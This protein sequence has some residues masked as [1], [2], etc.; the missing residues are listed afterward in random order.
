VV[1]GQVSGQWSAERSVVSWVVSGQLSGQ[2]SGQWSAER[3][4]VSGVSVALVSGVVSASC[5]LCP[6]DKCRSVPLAQ[7]HTSTAHPSICLRSRPRI[8]WD[9]IDIF[10]RAMRC[11][12]G[13]C[14]HAV[15]VRPSVTFVDH[16]KT[17]KDIFEIFSPSGSDTILVF[18]PKG[19]ADIPT[20][21]PLTG[22]SNARW[23][24]K[25][26]IFFT[27]ISLYLRNGNS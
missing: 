19:G 15:S 25:M 3:S 23:Y 4:V 5:H 17:N 24:D 26:T 1:S 12:R 13:L 6:D 11:K 2:L 21:T 27:N 9:F 18:P 20:G 22:S 14:C 8:R 7:S 16:V 10:Y